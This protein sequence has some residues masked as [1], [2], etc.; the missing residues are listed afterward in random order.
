MLGR[1]HQHIPHNMAHFYHLRTK[2]SISM[3]TLFLF[4]QLLKSGVTRSHRSG[5]A[6]DM[7]L[8]VTLRTIILP[9]G[10]G[11]RTAPRITSVTAPELY[12][13]GQGG[14][15]H[16]AFPIPPTNIL[17]LKITAELRPSFGYS[18]KPPQ[19]SLSER[20]EAPR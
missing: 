19:S 3:K 17:S 9:P 8:T 5:G 12:T 15:K 13:A 1:H 20:L 14:R 18:R 6:G 11:Q 2:P 16:N 10:P 4:Q 7:S